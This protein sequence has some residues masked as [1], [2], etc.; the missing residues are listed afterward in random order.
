[1]WL[2]GRQIDFDDLVEILFG[3]LVYLRIAGE[4]LPNAVGEVSNFLA[5]GTTEVLCHLVVIAEC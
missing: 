5:A 1:M 4:V 3:I 2:Q